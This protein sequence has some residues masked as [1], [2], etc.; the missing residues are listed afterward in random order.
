M[1]DSYIGHVLCSHPL[2]SF[3]GFFL[4]FSLYFPSSSQHYLCCRNFLVI[5][6]IVSGN[7]A[8]RVKVK[9]VGCLLH[10]VHKFKTWISEYILYFNTQYR[11]GKLYGAHLFCKRGGDMT[12]IPSH[13][14]YGP[15]GSQSWCQ[16][17]RHVSL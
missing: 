2:K 9:G 13:L 10:K 15:S 11:L 6:L 17:G 8:I 1:C 14:T 5:H 12:M 16:S 4:I 3:K 7:I